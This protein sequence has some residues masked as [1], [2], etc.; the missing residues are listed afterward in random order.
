[1]EPE[2]QLSPEDV[3]LVDKIVGQ[4]KSQ[5]IFD[6]F[7]KECMADV[8]T[9]PAYQNLRQRVDGSVASFLSN[10]QW[11]PDLNKNQL[12]DNLRKHIQNG[13]FL[14]IG[15]ERIVDQ[16][17]NPKICP[18]FLPMVEQ[19][20]YDCLGVERPD[21][22]EVSNKSMTSVPKSLGMPTYR[23]QF[24][25]GMR[26]PFFSRPPPPPISIPLPDEPQ[27][28][29]QSSMSTAK[30]GKPSSRSA[31][32]TT[33]ATAT[34]IS[35]NDILPKDVEPVSPASDLDKEEEDSIRLPENNHAEV[36]E[37][38]EEEEEE[39]SPP[40]E[41]HTEVHDENSV[42]SHVSGISELASHNSLNL[43]RVSSDS[44]DGK[45]SK[46]IQEGE[47]EE[48]S[49]MKERHSSS[50]E[51]SNDSYHEQKTPVI[52]TENSDHPTVEFTSVKEYHKYQMKSESHITDDNSDSENTDKEQELEDRKEW[53][54]NDCKSDTNV[55][56]LS[57]SCD[58]KNDGIS[59]GGEEIAD[60]SETTGDEQNRIAGSYDVFTDYDDDVS[61]SSNVIVSASDNDAKT[62]MYGTAY[63]VRNN[64]SE[65]SEDESEK[66]DAMKNK[67]KNS[68]SKLKSDSKKHKSSHRDNHG[69]YD[70]SNKHAERRHHHRHHHSKDKNKSE[71]HSEKKEKENKHSKSQ[72]VK[73]KSRHDKDKQNSS[74]DKSNE[75]DQSKDKSHKK[76]KRD[77]SSSK[78]RSKDRK[79]KKIVDE[80]DEDNDGVDAPKHSGGKKHDK[81]KRHKSKRKKSRDHCK[82]RSKDKG[83]RRST[84]RDSNDQGE[85]SGAHTTDS[86]S[87][88]RRQ[89]H[90]SGSSLDKE[91]YERSSN[92]DNVSESCDNLV[93]DVLSEESNRQMDNCLTP[94]RS[95]LTNSKL[96]CSSEKE[97]QQSPN[98][99]SNNSSSSNKKHNVDR[100]LLLKHHL[101]FISYNSN[102]QISKFK[103]PKIAA[104][105]Y[106]VRKVMQMRRYFKRLERQKQLEE[107]KLQSFMVHKELNINNS[108]G[109]GNF[110]N[111]SEYNSNGDT[112][113]QLK[114]NCD[115]EMI[116]HEF[117]SVS[118]TRTT[119]G[120]NNENSHSCRSSDSECN[121]YSYD[122]H[123]S[124]CDSDSSTS[125]ST[126]DSDDSDDEYNS[127]IVHSVGEEKC[128]N[129]CDSE[130]SK[131]I[132]NNNTILKD[133][134]KE[135]TTSDMETDD[136]K[137]F[138]DPGMSQNRL[139]LEKLLSE[140]EDDVKHAEEEAHNIDL[141][142][143][144]LVLN[145][146]YD[147][148]LEQQLGAKVIR[149]RL[150]VLPKFTEE[151]YDYDDESGYYILKKL[152]DNSGVPKKRK[153]DESSDTEKGNSMLLIPKVKQTSS[154]K[155]DH[156]DKLNVST[157]QI[158]QN[159]GQ[160]VKHKRRYTDENINSLPRDVPF[161][162]CNL[163]TKQSRH[164]NRIKPFKISFK[165][166]DE[167]HAQPVYNLENNV[168]YNMPSQTTNYV[169]KSD[170]IISS[171]I[172]TVVPNEYTKTNESTSL[173]NDS[174]RHWSDVL[175]MVV[176]NNENSVEKS[177]EN[178]RKVCRLKAMDSEGG[179]DIDDSVPGKFSKLTNQLIEPAL[180][181]LLQESGLLYKGQG[182]TELSQKKNKR[183]S[184]IDRLKLDAQRIMDMQTSPKTV[185]TIDS[186]LY[187]P[188]HI[189][190]QRSR[191]RL[192]GI[193]NKNIDDGETDASTS[194][195]ASSSS[196]SS[197]V[198]HEYNKRSSLA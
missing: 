100:H 136:F 59:A 26:P 38:G 194:S 170:Y 53:F 121:S 16:V 70:D 157:N 46:T 150:V 128:N 164:I 148:Y 125:D 10:H 192:R 84:D 2:K 196:S 153:S 151:N 139:Y 40:F 137:G 187:K 132:I 145:P 22:N 11:R 35:L 58:E 131:T 92:S 127:E 191:S 122:S 141:V 113:V 78:E 158:K 1:M 107:E 31:S 180:Q 101:N 17:V 18:I 27:P 156:N 76:R 102:G 75:K 195:S 181:N 19:V 138:H 34:L 91:S 186:D 177:E 124:S 29:Q 120:D 185:K 45:V 7:R 147:D 183:L 111:F 198:R 28:Q 103:K 174:S 112:E 14:D 160:Y 109:E 21:K 60:G 94:E 154:V 159:N 68:S 71:R 162:D 95:G 44:V 152:Y 175:D 193:V 20:V 55:R 39:V 23:P 37:E 115:H 99:I 72:N 116:Q 82:P 63:T 197:S 142:T 56:I 49:Q 57:D 32:L 42:D 87:S 36:E 9:K 144:L 129:T 13:G 67:H 105:I 30:D 3:K 119:D 73:E 47:T 66:S 69:K 173:E 165:K 118:H 65:K 50:D 93:T 126:S 15:V 61:N 12:R 130:L 43:S 74:R 24:F 64:E 161:E 81:H 133:A 106:E 184:S 190:G 79:P 85:G 86:S 110:Y 140:L 163:K 108:F 114:E 97:N 149:K 178:S 83:N 51:S 62:N 176:G 123:S 88:N 54:T 8:D 166:L 48:D 134:E 146:K 89:N 33:T 77:E 189:F 182:Q 6:Q 167:I 168:S 172:K 117:D 143:S 96:E 169:R 135:P 98:N 171:K 5:G 80:D 4:L 41:P 155:V 90:Q 104:N 179:K 52:H 25:P 188:R